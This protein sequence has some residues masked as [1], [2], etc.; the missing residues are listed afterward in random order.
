MDLEER[1]EAVTSRTLFFIVGLAKTGSTWLQLMFD[2]HP[3]VA[4]FGEDDLGE[5]GTDIAQ[6][7]STYNQRSVDRN[8]PRQI[9]HL[10][11]AEADI[12]PLIRAATFLAMSRQSLGDQVMAVGS[13][14]L[15]L[16]INPEPY[17]AIFPEA[18]FIH[19]KRD[20]RDILVSAY[21][22]NWNQNPDRA[23]E[24]FPTLAKYVEDTAGE[25]AQK[26]S[27]LQSF[28]T[29]AGDRYHEIRYED[30]VA[31]TEKTLLSALSFL[32]VTTDQTMARTAVD[33]ASFK[34]LSGGRSPGTEDKTS[35][36]RK[37]TPGDW[38]EKF[39][40]AALDAF[41]ASDLARV[42]RDFGYE[43]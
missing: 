24:H 34:K 38:R 39:D 28:A 16:Y 27:M 2:A 43:E 10:R 40:Q 35:F 15:N 12:A 26:A 5:L 9:N 13:R 36:F 31:S 18:R 41:H 29:R 3:A 32:D 20:P 19:I 8:M 17:F 42:L 33:A 22:Y 23:K 37:G 6:A 11:F 21:Y 30:L 25:W 1:I 14:Y 4:C 7:I